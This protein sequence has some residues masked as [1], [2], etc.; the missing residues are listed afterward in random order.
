MT[1]S[2]LQGAVG[3]RD[4][5]RGHFA[6]AAA[7]PT[8]DDP[9]DYGT[10]AMWYDPPA[11]SGSGY[12][13]SGSNVTQLTDKSGN[14]RHAVPV[15]TGPTIASVTA[16]GSK[17][18]LHF[19]NGS[20]LLL[21][22]SGTAVDIQAFAIVF[23]PTAVYGS[24]GSAGYLFTWRDNY[25]G[26]FIGN[27][28]SSQVGSGGYGYVGVRGFETDSGEFYS[29]VDR[30]VADFDTSTVFLVAG[31]FNGSNWDISI[32]SNYGETNLVTGDPSALLDVTSVVLG[33]RNQSTHNRVSVDMLQ[34]VYFEGAPNETDWPAYLNSLGTR[35]GITIDTSAPTAPALADRTVLADEAVAE[36]ID[37]TTDDTPGTNAVD[38]TSV[39]IRTQPTYG[40]VSVN[41]GTGV[42]TY[43]SD[44]D[45]AGVT[46]TFVVRY[47]DVEG[48]PSNEATVTVEISGSGGGASAIT[49]FMGEGIGDPF[50]MLSNINTKL[51]YNK[52]RAG[53]SIRAPKAGN[54]AKVR[55]Q[56]A[57]NQ[58]QGELDGG[59]KSLGTGVIQ[60]PT[61]C[62]VGTLTAPDLS[63][64]K[65]SWDTSHDRGTSGFGGDRRKWHERVLASSFA[66][67]EGDYVWLLASPQTSGYATNYVST[68]SAG[69][70]VNATPDR[71]LSAS[72]RL[73]VFWGDG[74]LGASYQEQD[75]ANKGTVNGTFTRQQDRYPHMEIV[76]DDGEVWSCDVFNQ[77]ENLTSATSSPNGG[78]AGSGR[79]QIGGNNRIRVIWEQDGPSIDVRYCHFL[80]WYHTDN[81][82]PT[83]DLSMTLHRNDGTIADPDWVLVDSASLAPGSIPGWSQSGTGTVSPVSLDMGSL[84]EITNG[85]IYKL[86]FYS[87][88]E[89]TSRYRTIAHSYGRDVMSSRDAYASRINSW[90]RKPGGSAT[91][92]AF[93]EYSTDGGS[94]WHGHVQFSPDERED[95]IISAFL[96]PG[97]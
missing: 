61:A 32:N 75:N 89:T 57:S 26:C 68:N 51:A 7:A 10:V 72:P 39:H 18:A 15:G 90:T 62:Y 83:H 86:E 12:T 82:T 22:W 46:D 28:A 38:V 67:V 21:Q 29:I 87:T 88:G 4:L 48:I 76:Y 95:R 33:G 17:D 5:H 6:S 23:K 85:E 97:P 79:S 45:T 20:A 81:G 69:M 9:S 49:K 19:L 59:E 1:F 43:T 47:R 25:K 50:F 3:T 63:D 74:T 58:S 53:Y 78:V 8:S 64:A 36:L 35:F 27:A 30:T 13:L 52:R 44:A 84:H 41:G 65:D 73:G 80:V 92:M 96:T 16:N 14:A 70:K 55:W 77:A 56:L 24:G 40:N 34:A 42:I 71:I 11:G 37:M 94:T 66:V 93:V 31:R 60:V 2:A 54:I 91:D